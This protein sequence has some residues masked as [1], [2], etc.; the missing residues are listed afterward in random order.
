MGEK[1]PPPIGMVRY[2]IAT[3]EKTLI[4]PYVLKAT[5]IVSPSPNPSPSQISQQEDW[6]YPGFRTV[7]Q[8][9]EFL[10]I[11][12][13][14]LTEPPGKGRGFTQLKDCAKRANYFPQD[15][16]PI[17]LEKISNWYQEKAK[18]YGWQFQDQNYATPETPRLYT[19]GDQKLYIT[20]FVYAQNP[21]VDLCWK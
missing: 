17:E 5:P 16:G 10:T 20:A 3:G 8:S 1:N 9:E 12:K 15:L 4:G 7:D 18:S 19:K 11:V 2:D 21:A 14:S 6:Q 13:N